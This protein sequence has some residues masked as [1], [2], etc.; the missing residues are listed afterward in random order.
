MVIATE[1]K[2]LGEEIIASY[3]MRIKAVG[4][5]VRIPT[6]CSRN[7]TR[8]TKICLPNR[9]SRWLILSKS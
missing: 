1:M 6:K 7:S 3:D 9:P 2:N 5:L 4:G 8:S